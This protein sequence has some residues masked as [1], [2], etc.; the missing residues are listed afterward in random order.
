MAK[1]DR[2]I[3]RPLR[4]F[5][6]GFMGAG[7]TS[8]GRELARLLR[9]PFRDTDDE[10]RSSS[11]L[12]PGVFIERRGLAAFR[13]AESAAFGRLAAGPAAVIALGGG[14]CPSPRRRAA[15]RRAGVTVWLS[16]PLPEMT[17]LAGRQGGRPLLARGDAAVRRLFSARE[18]HYAACDLKVDAAGLTP[19][20]AARE[21]RRQLEK[22]GFI[23]P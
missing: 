16:R 2:E 4:I 1:K 17:R 19:S 9:L 20:A 3:H 11:G 7:K 23:S 12:E 8:S 5:L 21:I 14:L 6:A 22:N 10:V 18:K 13:R 15:F